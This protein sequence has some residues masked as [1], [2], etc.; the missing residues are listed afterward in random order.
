MR[1]L[2]DTN[3]ISVLMRDPARRNR[4]VVAWLAGV[5]DIEL[6]TSALVVREVWDGI[7][8]ARA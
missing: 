7:E 1:Y 8:S 6:C 3:V 4:H 5:D 2:L